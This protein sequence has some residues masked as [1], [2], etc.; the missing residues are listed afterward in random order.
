MPMPMRQPIVLDAWS[1][2]DPSPSLNEI[3]HQIPQSNLGSHD[4]DSPNCE[5]KYHG[6]STLLN[7]YSALPAPTA[8]TRLEEPYSATALMQSTRTNNHHI[9]YDGDASTNYV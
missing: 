2:P 3:G 4:C 7:K 9:Q 6:I 1:F 8:I 5:L